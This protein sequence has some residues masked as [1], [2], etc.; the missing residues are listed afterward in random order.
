MSNMSLRCSN[1]IKKTTLEENYRLISFL[2]AREIWCEL[3]LE[4]DVEMKQRIEK[5]TKHRDLNN[6]KLTREHD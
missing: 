1:H 5:A 2:Q 4:S 6:G 3:L